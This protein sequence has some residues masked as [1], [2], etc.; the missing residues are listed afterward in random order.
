MTSDYF[1]F[2]MSQMS[3]GTQ[4]GCACLKWV[5]A[6]SPI[7]TWVIKWHDYSFLMCR[8]SRVSHTY[9]VMRLTPCGYA[10]HSNSFTR[11]IV[12]LTQH[13]QTTRWVVYLCNVTQNSS[14]NS[15]M[16]EFCVTLHKYTTH[17]W[18]EYRV[19]L[20]HTSARVMSHMWMS[21]VS[22]YTYTRLIVNEYITFSCIHIIIESIIQLYTYTHTTHC[23]WIDRAVVYIYS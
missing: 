7:E 13:I 11:L 15:S 16:D 23:Q 21:S 17:C 2:C 9:L 19:Q 1:R 10:A 5:M 12:S 18:C 14:M 20:C 6:H 22:Y 3:H 4:M 8:Q